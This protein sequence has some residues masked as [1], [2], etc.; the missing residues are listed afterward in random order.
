MISFDGRVVAIA[1]AAAM[2]LSSAAAQNRASERPFRNAAVTRPRIAIV[3]ATQPPEASSRAAIA[4]RDA[5]ALARRLREIGFEVRT[6]GPAPRPE[7]ARTVRDVAAEVPAGADVAVLAMGQSLGG[8]DDVFLP[9]AGTSPDL[10]GR[11]DFLDTQA[12]RLGDL[13]RHIA[14]RRPADLVAVVDE[15]RPVSGARCPL[16]ETVGASG[17]SLIAAER[18]SARGSN[19]P[20]ASQSSLRDPLLRATAT[21]GQSFLQVYDALQS[22]L[23]RTDLTV[24]ASSRLSSTFSF[25]PAG[26]F[27][28]LGTECNRVDPAADPAAIRALS[29]EP[30]LAACQAALDAHPYSEF[31]RAQLGAAKEQQSLQRAL[32]SCDRVAASTYRAAYPA[33]RYRVIVDDVVTDCERRETDRQRDEARRRDQEEEALFRGAVVSCGDRRDAIAYGTR[34]PSG[35]F[36][37]PVDSFLRDCQAADRQRMVEAQQREQ[38]RQEAARREQERQEAARREQDDRRRRDYDD[39]R[40]REQEQQ[41]LVARAPISSR[42]GWT[43][44]YATALMHVDPN[45]ADAFTPDG[46]ITTFLKPNSPYGGKVDFFIQ[47]GENKQCQTANAWA[48]RVLSRNRPQITQATGISIAGQRAFF[49]KGTSFKGDPSTSF[50]DIVL[51]PREDPNMFVHLGV[52][53]PAEEEDKWRDEFFRVVASYSL[54]PSGLIR[55]RC[56]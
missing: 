47:A 13:L 9:P 1:I 33:G 43:A 44:T 25:I 38:E 19:G 45:G 20:V 34:Y 28:G 55:G 46:L 6:I 22:A 27:R 56:R 42:A 2:A 4:A 30:L 53:Y 3:L 39:Q 50:I 36:R 32:A 37:T 8:A 16:D 31:F 10:V 5:E 35:R 51:I 26:Y 52:Q 49:Q 14:D 21:E 18:R 24:L 40:R 48:E 29:L 15:C 11:P 41:A 23:A 7:L 12:I 17:A 54:S